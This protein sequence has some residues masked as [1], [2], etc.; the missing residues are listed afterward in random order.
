MPENENSIVVTVRSFVPALNPPVGY[1]FGEPFKMELP[2]G[3]TVRELGEKIL[4][5]NINQLGIT[6][7]NGKVAQAHVVLSQG[8]RVDLYALIEGG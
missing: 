1:V 7:I 6:A 2:R 5:K 4:A 8:D 3:I